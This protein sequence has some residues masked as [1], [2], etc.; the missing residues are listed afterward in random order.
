MGAMG[1]LL[2]VPVDLQLADLVLRDAA[3]ERC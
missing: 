2:D 1:L 3:L